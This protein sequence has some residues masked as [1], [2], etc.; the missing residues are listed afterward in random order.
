MMY[1]CGWT[2]HLLGVSSIHWLSEYTRQHWVLLR[3][4][5][6]HNNR[7]SLLIAVGG[8]GGIHG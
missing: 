4:P 3:Y 5:L 1:T 2:A 7:L 8:L 6:T